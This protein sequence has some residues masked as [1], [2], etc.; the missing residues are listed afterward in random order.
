[1]DEHAALKTIFDAHKIVMEKQGL[2]EQADGLREEAKEA[3]DNA[4][5][6]LNERIQELRTGQETLPFEGTNGKVADDARLKDGGAGAP[7]VT[8]A[9]AAKRR[10]KKDSTTNPQ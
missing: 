7:P 9:E 6:L 4:Q 8:P 1:M 5:I 3:L 2:F 10:R